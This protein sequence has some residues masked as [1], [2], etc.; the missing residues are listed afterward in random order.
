[1]TV[2]LALPTSLL[3]FPK[4]ITLEQLRRNTGCGEVTESDSAIV[5]TFSDFTNSVYQASLPA[6][7]GELVVEQKCPALVPFKPD[8][9]FK[10][11]SIFS[12]E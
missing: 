10:T 5:S 9:L 11:A 2:S 1:M 8:N 7:L 12:R 4:L 3:K 6:V